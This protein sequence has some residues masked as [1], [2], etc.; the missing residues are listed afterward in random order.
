MMTC[1]QSAWKMQDGGNQWSAWSAYISF[2]RYV[3]LL[4][5]D[6]S[7]WD[8]YEK[9]AMHAGPRWLHPKFCIV[10]DRP[11][12]L[13][14]DEKNR[15]HC[16][17]GPFCRWRDGSRLYSIHGV[18]VPGLLI[19]YPELVT[20]EMIEEE[21]DNEVSKLMFER[22]PPAEKSIRLIRHMQEAD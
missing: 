19:E 4:G 15:P 17:D 1:A 13:K 6:Y 20:A 3:A 12:V 10:S 7:K 5:L 18:R 22:C 8:H 14:I 2:F 11:E 9:A 21:Q 16:D